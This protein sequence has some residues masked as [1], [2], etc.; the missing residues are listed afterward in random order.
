VTQTNAASAEES[1]SASEELNAQAV[2]MN[3]AVGELLSMVGGKSRWQ[4]RQEAQA[5][6][7]ANGSRGG[8]TQPP[9][10]HPTPI[11]PRRDQDTAANQMPPAPETAA[12]TS[13]SRLEIPLDADFEDEHTAKA[14]R[15]A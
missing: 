6:P 8:L 11:R 9:S 7:I 2:A 1:A 12:A 15:D 4:G 5:A 13:S 3:E 10:R 14:F